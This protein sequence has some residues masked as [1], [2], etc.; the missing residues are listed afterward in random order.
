MDEI[1]QGKLRRSV[2]GSKTAVQ[3]GGKLIGYYAKRPFLSDAGKDRAREQMEEESAAIVF[4]ALS[5]LKGT[6]VKIAQMLS[7]E[8]DIFPE[9]I[10]RELA[11]S[12]NQV[13]PMNQVM[14]LK[15]VGNAFNSPL[16]TNYKSFDTQAFAAASLGQVHRAIDENG[17]LLA[18][19]V[20]YPGIGKSIKDD[21]QMVRQVLR[22]L[23]E[24]DI[25]LPVLEEIEQ[26]LEEEIDYIQE[27]DNIEWFGERMPEN[28]FCIP[29][30]KK[31]LSTDTVLSMT[32]LEG[33]PLNEW[34]KSSPDQEARDTV[35]QRLYDWF[36]YCFYD[37][38]CIHADPNPGN[39]IIDDN[40]N[41]GIVDFGCV[42]HFEP[43]FV[44]KYRA[45]IRALSKKDRDIHMRMFK[46]FDL[47]KGEPE[48]SLENHLNEILKSFSDWYGQLVA[49]PVF[50]FGANP[51]FMKGAKAVSQNIY[52]IRQHMKLNPNFVYLDRTRYG[53]LRLFEQL[54][55][56]VSIQNT[57]ES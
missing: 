45:L 24:Y 15:T 36:L 27:A 11:K 19:K 48:P 3:V 29:E 31:E 46:E 56:R 23:S 51:D 32:L 37:L 2:I 7:V 25:I 44:E 12:Y 52:K 33:L 13:P 8:M 35:A 21:M 38:N 43:E 20:Q 22:P 57:Y 40:L 49:G 16:E 47:F 28:G 34:L 30:V 5:L 39:F 55:A 41:V 50:D 53:M 9:S 17:I 18:V 10:C 1:P 14:V 54:R 4:Q 42:R 6:A 26:R